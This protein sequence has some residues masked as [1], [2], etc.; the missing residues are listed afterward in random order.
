[1]EISTKSLWI[2]VFI[3]FENSLFVRAIVIHETCGLLTNPIKLVVERSCSV[4]PHN[5]LSQPIN[6]KSIDIKIHTYKYSRVSMLP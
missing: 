5:L 1:V 2:G 4:K 3:L 6:F